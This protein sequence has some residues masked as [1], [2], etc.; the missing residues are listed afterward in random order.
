MVRARRLLRLTDFPVQ[1]KR[2][3]LALHLATECEKLPGQFT[4]SFSGTENLTMLRDSPVRFRP[5]GAAAV[6]NSLD[7]P[8]EGC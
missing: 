5:F 3:F 7:R 1:V 4:A 2:L 6:Q 8:G